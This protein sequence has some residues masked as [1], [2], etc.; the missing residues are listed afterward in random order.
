MASHSA[1]S[2]DVTKQLKNFWKLKK[3]IKSFEEF[4]KFLQLNHCDQITSVVPESGYDFCLL[5]CI[6]ADLT[7]CH[8]VYW[9]CQHGS[10]QLG[11]TVRQ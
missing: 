11:K 7:E 6:T 4:T 9:I 5:T 3:I 1:K 10:K 2:K 8:S